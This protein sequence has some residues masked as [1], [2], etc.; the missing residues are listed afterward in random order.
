M[1][2]RL[3]NLIGH[4]FIHS[5]LLLSQGSRLSGAITGGPFAGYEPRAGFVKASA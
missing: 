3:L 5:S 2:A 4:A 1:K